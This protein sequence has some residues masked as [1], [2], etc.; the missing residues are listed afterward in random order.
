MK[1]KQLKRRNNKETK[2]KKR[3]KQTKKIIG[4][5]KEKINK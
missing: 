4:N 2:Q 1:K 5:P 3:T